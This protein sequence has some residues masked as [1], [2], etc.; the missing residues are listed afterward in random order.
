MMKLYIE[1]Q[2]YTAKPMDAYNLE[3]TPLE[4]CNVCGKRLRIR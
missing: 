4:Y 1:G 2:W 3:L